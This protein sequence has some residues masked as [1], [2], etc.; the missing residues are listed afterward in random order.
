MASLISRLSEE[1]GSYR[2]AKSYMY[3]IDNSLSEIGSDSISQETVV[4]ID[5]DQDYDAYRLATTRQA[6]MDV[7]DGTNEPLMD[8]SSMTV[9]HI[10]A[11]DDRQLGLDYKWD[12]NSKS[13]VNSELGMSVARDSCQVQWDGFVGNLSEFGVNLTKV[14]SNTTITIEQDGDSGGLDP[15]DPLDP[16]DPPPDPG[17]DPD[18]IVIAGVSEIDVTVN[19]NSF[20]TIRLAVVQGAEI[21]GVKGMDTSMS[22]NN[23]TKTLTGWMLGPGP[24]EV[25]VELTTESGSDSAKLILRAGPISR[26]II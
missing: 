25:T 20:Y 1:D 18:T 2:L 6:S 19:P 11:D 10:L 14:M 5:P 13:R 16:P 3:I 9:F 22:W 15:D 23:L 4:L 12:P 17:D 21:K 7:I 24:K 26:H 8:T